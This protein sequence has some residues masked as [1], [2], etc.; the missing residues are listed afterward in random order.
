MFKNFWPKIVIALGVVGPGLIA[1]AANNDAG[2]I[3]TYAYAGSRFGYLLLW[4]LTL[5]VITL[6]VTQSVGARLGIYTGKGLSALIRENFGVRATVLA[7]LTLFIANTAVSASEMAGIASSFEIFGVSKFITVPIFAVLIWWILY[8]G[9]FKKVERFFLLISL[10]FVVYVFAAVMAQPDWAEVGR[11]LTVPHFSFGSAYLVAF[12]GIMGTTVTPWG[13]F[14]IQSYIVDKG[15]SPKYFK[16]EKWEVFLS[17]FFTCLIAAMIIITTKNVLYD[18]GI[19]VDSAKSAALSLRPILGNWAEFL[20]GFGFFC[21]SL[22]GAFILPL[23]TSYTICEALGFEYGMNRT[24]KEAPWFYGLM[25]VI[26]GI[27][28]VIVLLPF[29][30]LFHIMVSAQV[31]NAILL[32]VILVFVALLMNKTKKLGLP[33]PSKFQKFW[34]NLVTWEAVVR[35]SLVSLLLL[36]VSIFPN[37]GDHIINWAKDILF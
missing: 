29:L 16:I 33:E 21:A 11:A 23:T 26:I 20:F 28:S 13:Q 32:P 3:S 24:W 31:V 12:L 34:Y 30:S 19:V 9:S 8:K 35:L 22:L 17:A 27:A 10:F 1:G 15:V 36:V 25:A 6:F 2:G 5:N 14:F 37:A 18:N 7:L 4:V